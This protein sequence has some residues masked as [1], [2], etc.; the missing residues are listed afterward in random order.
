VLRSPA[1]QSIT[2]TAWALAHPRTRRL[3]RPA[4]RIR[5]V[6]SNV[7]T[8]PVGLCHQIR[9]PPALCPGRK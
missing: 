9:N 6:L 1:R 7:S 8:P 2:G 5:W 4:S 3:N